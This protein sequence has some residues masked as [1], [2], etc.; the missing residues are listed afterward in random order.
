MTSGEEP[1]VPEKET[2]IEVPQLNVLR[3]IDN[4]EIVALWA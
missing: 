2:K 3:L 4:Q 1:K